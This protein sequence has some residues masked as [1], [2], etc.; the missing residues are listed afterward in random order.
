M[1]FDPQDQDMINLLTRLKNA[2]SEY[3]EHMLVA[4]RQSFLKQMTEV[5]LGIGAAAG[6][7]NTLGKTPRRSHGV[8]IW[9]QVNL[10]SWDMRSTRLMSAPNSI[11]WAP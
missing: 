1:E 10:S 7:K 3:P 5:G 8:L 9:P 11:C 6:I 4:R 2:V